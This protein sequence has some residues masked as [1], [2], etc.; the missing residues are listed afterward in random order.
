[1]P[2]STVYRRIPSFLWEKNKRV[3]KPAAFH[4]RQGEFGLS[5]FDTDLMTPRGTLQNAID[6][7]KARLESD[8]EEERERGKNFL[9]KYGNTVEELVQNGWGVAI[10]PVDW[11]TEAGFT[12][13]GPE[14]NGHRNVIGSRDDFQTHSLSWLEAHVLS[15]EAVLASTV[16][17]P[18]SPL[19]EQPRQ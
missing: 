15:D 11:F 8:S 6:Y 17:V 13:D 9:D 19:P 14:P 18:S 4:I 2:A 3:P 1:M 5:V 12:L 7:A 10:L 16:T